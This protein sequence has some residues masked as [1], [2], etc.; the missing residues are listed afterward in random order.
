MK[1]CILVFFLLIS[2]YFVSGQIPAGYYNSAQGLTGTALKA[3]LHNIIKDHNAQS[4][5][6]LISYFEQTDKKSN[7]TV[8]D[9]YSDV[10]GGTPPYVYYYNNNDECGNYNQEGDCYNREHGFPQSW[11]DE[12]MPMKSDMFHI[13]PTDGFVNGK[14]SNYPFGKV[15]SPDW[16][17]ENG[18]RL[19]NCSTSGYT[20][21]VFEP[22]DAYKGDIARTYFYMAT[23]YYTEDG[24]WPG[25]PMVDGCEPKAWALAMLKQW[26]TQDPVSPKEID[27]NNAIYLIQNNRN[28]FI[29]HPEFVDAIWG[30]T[31][32]VSEIPSLAVDIYPNP[33]Y[34]I[35]NVTISNAESVKYFATVYNLEGKQI[36]S[37]VTSREGKFTLNTSGLSRGVYILNLTSEMQKVN[38]YYKIV[39]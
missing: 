19:G 12:A 3:A 20:G 14:R 36:I 18:S 6:S 16:V 7:N 27:R 26:T 33:V 13:Y 2:L 8:W 9:I 1:K 24:S 39:K 34:D 32:E 30:S 31:S 17:S 38:Y 4:Y 37:P 21:I 11:F 29:D 5:S 23:R 22:I 10:P 35:C 25:S 28:P 15:N